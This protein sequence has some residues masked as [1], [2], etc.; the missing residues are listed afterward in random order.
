MSEQWDCVGQ[1]M[2]V[3]DIVIGNINL[4]ILLGINIVHY[5][6]QLHHDLFDSS[7]QILIIL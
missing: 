1:A 3:G 5:F 4:R 2:G 7:D 6:S